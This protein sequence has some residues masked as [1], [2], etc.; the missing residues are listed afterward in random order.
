MRS[1]YFVKLIKYM[2]NVYIIERG[3][4]ELSDGRKYPKYTTANV[5]LPLLLGFM[6]R[7]KSM[8]ELKLMLYE[9]EFRNVFLRNIMLPQIDTIRDTI[10][11]IE[12]DGLRY[13]LTFTVKKAIQNKVFDNGTIDGYTVAALDGTKIFGSYKKCCPEC[14]TTMIK[15]KKYYYHYTS[16]MSIIR[17]GP[18]LTL[19]FEICRPREGQS[20]DEGEL[21]AS[22]HLISDVSGAFRNFIDMIVYDSLA[23]NSIWL[24]QCIELGADT[25]VRV[26]K[27]KN[28]SIRKV[29]REVNKQDPIEIW[30]DEEK[31]ENI[32]VYESELVMDYVEQPLR[33]VKY[34]IKHPDKKRSQIMIVTTNMNMSLKTLF[35]MIRARW[36]I[37]N[38]T[39][40]NLKNV[41]NLEHCF[42]HGGKAVEAIL[43]LIFFANNLMQLILI[44][45]LEID[46][47]LRK[48]WSDYC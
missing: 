8:N 6:L 26:K 40:N 22:K 35:K 5:I 14:L 3:I 27:N 16:V 43:Y 32:I 2:K 11:V 47:R 10:K 19:G 48:R 37:E 28:N 9:N 13:I 33:F 7:I 45:R 25:I 1:N 29:K 38:S 46:I 30:T 34:A 42:V 20:K 36:H 18:K 15:G 23:C 17:D 24:N 21:V 39:F 41:C 12:L 31:F 4:N 44:R